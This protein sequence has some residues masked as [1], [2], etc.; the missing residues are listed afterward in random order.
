ML[1]CY[2]GLTCVKVSSLT[3]FVLILT[4]TPVPIFAYLWH[5]FK[6]HMSQI[7]T[8][9]TAGM[10]KQL[11]ARDWKG[12]LQFIKKVILVPHLSSK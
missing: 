4:T 9:C 6:V 11:G 12:A 1:L 7:E 5:L 2:C 10:E 3:F 8:R